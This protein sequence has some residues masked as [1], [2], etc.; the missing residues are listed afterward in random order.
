M[1]SVAKKKAI[2]TLKEK[3]ALLLERAE[4]VYSEMEELLPAYAEE[5]R[6][7]NIPPGNYL[8][9][10]RARGLGDCREVIRAAIEGK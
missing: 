8:M 7:S 6:H 10:W 9:V 1:K 3:L 5:V 4:A 2:P